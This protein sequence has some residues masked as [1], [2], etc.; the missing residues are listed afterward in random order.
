[1]NS[2]TWKIATVNVKG[3][4]NAEKFDDIMNWIIHEDFDITILTET[5]LRLILAIFYSSKYKKNYTLH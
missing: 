4:N 3:M 5:K 2:N 1:M